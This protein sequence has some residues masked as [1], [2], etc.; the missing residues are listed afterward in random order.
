MRASRYYPSLSPLAHTSASLSNK[1]PLSLS[2]AH[3][4]LLPGST[5]TPNVDPATPQDS[6]QLLRSGHGLCRPI[7]LSDEEL[8]KLEPGKSGVIRKGKLNWEL[9]VRL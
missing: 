7:P 4:L 8:V 1:P 6:T 3:S 5:S 2:I 9:W